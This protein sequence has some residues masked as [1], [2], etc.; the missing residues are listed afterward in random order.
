LDL[1]QKKSSKVEQVSVYF[2]NKFPLTIVFS[3]K[4]LKKLAGKN[5]IEDALKKLDRLTQ[6]EARMASAQLLKITNAMDSEVREIAD[7][8]LVVDDRVAGV[9]DRVA[10]VN[11]RVAVI[12][13]RV[14]DVHDR[15]KAVDNKLVGVFDG[16]QYLQSIIEDCLTLDACRRKRG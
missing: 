11:E 12:D 1:Q 2:A 9:D 8:V 13:D 4:Y 16:A 14:K 7:N 6:E 5:D 3:A 15:V 10:A